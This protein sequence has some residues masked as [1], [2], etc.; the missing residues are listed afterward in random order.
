ML[1]DAS[2]KYS[3]LAS[4]FRSNPD[5]GSEYDFTRYTNITSVVVTPHV[6]FVKEPLLSQNAMHGLRSY[7]G[8]EE[9]QNWLELQSTKV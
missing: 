2:T 7:L 9:F 4:Y 6:M 5:G 3:S 8:F 1:E